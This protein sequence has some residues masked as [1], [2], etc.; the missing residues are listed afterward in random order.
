FKV[1][2]F[3]EQTGTALAASFHIHSPV[4]VLTLYACG[5]NTL[6][7]VFL[8]Q[9]EQDK[10]GDYGQSR[11]CQR[12]APVG[13]R[14]CVTDEGTQRPRNCE[15]VWSC[16]VQQMIE[17]VVPRPQEGEQRRRDQRGAGER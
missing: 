17:E 1:S 3:C 7:E 10:G 11:H 15:G 4:I 9:E 16:Q 12:T 6:Y 13:H 5:R 8:K 14:A 2:S